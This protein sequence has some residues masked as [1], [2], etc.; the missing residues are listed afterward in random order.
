[1]GRTYFSLG[2]ASTVDKMNVVLQIVEFPLI[3]YSNLVQGNY[4]PV[5]AAAAAS[6]FLLG[7]PDLG[8][9]YAVLAQNYLITGAIFTAADHFLGSSKGAAVPGAN[10]ELGSARGAMFY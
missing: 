6:V 3:A 10:M 8:A 7:V 9:D 5:A 2:K 1:M 4:V